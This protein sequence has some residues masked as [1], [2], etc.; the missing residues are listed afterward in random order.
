ML[1]VKLDYRWLWDK[2]GLVNSLCL[3]LSHSLL[4]ILSFLLLSLQSKSGFGL[5]WT[6]RGVGK[7]TGSDFETDGDISKSLTGAG[8]PR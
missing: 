4:L 7:A 6:N 2:N 8:K 3:S 1:L 5:Y